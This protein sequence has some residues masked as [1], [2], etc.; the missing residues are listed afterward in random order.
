MSHSK[1]RSLLSHQRDGMS[2]FSLSNGPIKLRKRA[3]YNLERREEVDAVR[4]KGSCLRCSLLKIP[5]SKDDLCT[6]CE[7]LA[8][9]SRKHNRKTLSFFGCIRTKLSEVSVFERYIT[10]PVDDEALLQDILGSTV[11]EISIEFATPVIWDLN[12]LVE[13]TVNWLMDP[14]LSDTSKVGILASPQFL[15]LTRG[16]DSSRAQCDAGNNFSTMIYTT[17]RAHVGQNGPVLTVEDYSRFGGATGHAF[18]VYLDSILKPAAL[19]Q[20]SQGEL[21]TAFL[22]VFGTILAV[23]YTGYSMPVHLQASF[24]AMRSHLCQILAHYLV[25]VSSRLDLSLPSEMDHF[26][27]EG[28]KCRWD[29]EGQFRW[30]RAQS[31]IADVHSGKMSSGCGQMDLSNSVHHSSEG[32][33]PDFMRNSTACS[34]WEDHTVLHLQLD[35]DWQP[36][37]SSCATDMDVVSVR[38]ESR[39]ATNMDLVSVRRRSAPPLATLNPL[40]TP[41]KL[42]PS[43][44]MVERLNGSRAMPRTRSRKELCGT[45]AVQHGL[46]SC[47]QCSSSGVQ[48]EITLPHEYSD[49]QLRLSGAPEE[50]LNIRPEYLL[51]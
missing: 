21:Q 47:E 35:R 5:C 41:R 32:S 15:E 40:Y 12:T 31:T 33:E 45:C 26:I 49:T 18:L 2:S 50:E 16:P 34:P 28:A 27:L 38:R 8:D 37:F 11:R 23:G 51:V 29:K 6:T 13:D 10:P 20:C 19:R 9:V 17:S 39:C 30:K 24:E 22:W 43:H 46:G 44:Q 1:K 3:K 7:Q 14:G 48:F 4:K 42:E 36:G 25:Y